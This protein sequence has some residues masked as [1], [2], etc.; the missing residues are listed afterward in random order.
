MTKAERQER[1]H[2]RST[3]HLNVAFERIVE[4]GI[5]PADAAQSMIL[6]GAGALVNHMTGAAA[7][8]TVMEARDHIYSWMTQI[9]E[10][11]GEAGGEHHR[12]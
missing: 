11:V 6:F 8:A 7:R 10:K 12:A 3:P 9:A 4:H 5:T 1:A 2:R